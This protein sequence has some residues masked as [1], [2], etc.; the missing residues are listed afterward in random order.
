MN[1]KKLKMV[2]AVDIPRPT[3]QLSLINKLKVIAVK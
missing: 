2:K 3:D 1:Q